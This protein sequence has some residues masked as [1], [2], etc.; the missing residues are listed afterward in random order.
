MICKHGEC[1]LMMASLNGK[2]IVMCEN[3]DA[4]CPKPSE[5]GYKAVLTKDC[6]KD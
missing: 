3:N 6:F 4:D 5:E 2:M 1:R